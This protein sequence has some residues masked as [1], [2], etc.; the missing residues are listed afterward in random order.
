MVESESF[1][2]AFAVTKKTGCLMVYGS[3]S[4]KLGHQQ[5]TY[6]TDVDPVFI[7]SGGLYVTTRTQLENS[8]LRYGGK[9]GFIEVPT[10]RN[11]DINSFEDLELAEAI[12]SSRS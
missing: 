3:K 10:I 9:I 4:Y 6:E 5:Q 7:E 1:D 8:K 11:I 12:I 2:S